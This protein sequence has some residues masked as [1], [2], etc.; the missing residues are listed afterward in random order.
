[1]AVVVVKNDVFEITLIPA[2]GLSQIVKCCK[3]LFL[4]MVPFGK[5][6][7]YPFLNNSDVPRIG[8][9]FSATT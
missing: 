9:Q 2:D 8:E 7:S 1:M 3:W 5:S 6:I 4:L